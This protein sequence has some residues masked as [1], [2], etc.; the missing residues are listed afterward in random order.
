[1]K[2]L[3]FSLGAMALLVQVHA[4]TLIELPTSLTSGDYG[5]HNSLT[6]SFG[7]GSYRLF[8]GIALS[9]ADVGK[10][11][12]IGSNTDDPDYSAMVSALTSGV[13]DNYL[14]E[15]RTVGGGSL[16]WQTRASTLFASASLGWPDLRGYEIGSFTL[17]VNGLSMVSPGTD[18]NHN[19][20]W[21]DI[22]AS[23]SLDINPIPEPSICALLVI[24]FGYLLLRHVW[25]KKRD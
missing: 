22:S 9:S 10:S 1:M 21:T 23:F 3:F 12:T 13:N 11:F 20:L 24:P 6:Y 25:R 7:T 8:D 14:R 18:P 5:V 16:S 2:S 15:V 4:A 17:H 19:G